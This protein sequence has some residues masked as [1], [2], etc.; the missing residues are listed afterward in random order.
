MTIRSDIRFAFQRAV[1]QI[2]RS[3]G[4]EVRY[5]FQNPPITSAKI[6][7]PWI[8]DVT[9]I[10]DV[11]ANVGQSASRFAK[12]FGRSTVY[13]FEPFPVAYRR[14]EKV[15]LSSKGR[16]RAYQLACGE[17]EG[18]MIVDD[19]RTASG[20]NQLRPQ[21]SLSA[22]PT[23]AI[24]VST[25]DRICERETITKID[26]L[27]TDTEGYDAKVLVGATGML[28]EGRVRA[29]ISEIG[30]IDD[31]QHTEFGSVFLLLN[32]YDF[33]IAGIYEISYSK[34]FQCS[35]ANALFVRRQ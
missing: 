5:A 24:D 23:I 33:E 11:G 27:K 19:W 25:V 8:S 10:F 16:I 20:L 12:E 1:K 34:D 35:Y 22:G 14:L 6:Y 2:T 32:K 26:I 28:S 15:A 21:Q 18:R 13:S 9:T 17:S 4:I 31:S 30:F 7:A 29:V 3:L